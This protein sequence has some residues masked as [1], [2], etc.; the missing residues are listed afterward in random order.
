MFLVNIILLEGG[1]RFHVLCVM[2]WVDILGLMMPT[3]LL[4]FFLLLEF[5][6]VKY[7]CYSL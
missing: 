6:F 2:S 3:E 4:I 1:W 7:D 5:G